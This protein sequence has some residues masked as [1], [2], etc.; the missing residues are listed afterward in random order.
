MLRIRGGVKKAFGFLRP[1]RDVLTVERASLGQVWELLESDD[2]DVAQ[3]RFRWNAVLV[4]YDGTYFSALAK[5]PS[6]ELDVDE[7]VVADL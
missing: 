2:A 7:S 5:I 3:V 1:S 4:A 6:D